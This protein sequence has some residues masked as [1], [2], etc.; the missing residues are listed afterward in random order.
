MGDGVGDLLSVGADVLD[1]RAA[2]AA[3]DTGEALDAADS[4]LAD[5]EDEGVPV[6]A[7][8]DCV[9]D[10]VACA[11]GFSGSV[12]GDV[13]DQAVEAPVADQ[14]IAAAAEDEDRAALRSRAKLHGFEELGFGANVAEETG[15]A[16]DAEGGVGRER[17]MLLNVEDWRG[18]GSRVQHWTA[19]RLTR[20]AR[21]RARPYN[22]ERAAV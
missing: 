16:T 12:D 9:I 15:R 22:R 20:V 3:G 8:G 19:G 10:E 21:W 14:E 2:D 13:E 7:G 17:D 18:T 5:V 4:L 1:G 11:V 6:G